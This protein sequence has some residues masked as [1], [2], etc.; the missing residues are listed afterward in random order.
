M[1]LIGKI[2]LSEIEWESGQKT[3]SDYIRSRP[4]VQAQQFMIEPKAV[5]CESCSS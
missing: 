1:I 5:Q 3:R 2:Y 4:K